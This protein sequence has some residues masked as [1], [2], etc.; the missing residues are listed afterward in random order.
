MGKKIKSIEEWP[1]QRIVVCSMFK[2]NMSRREAHC[3]LQFSLNLTLVLALKKIFLH[4]FH[5]SEHYDHKVWFGR[6]GLE[7]IDWEQRQE[8]SWSELLNKKSILKQ[9]FFLEQLSGYWKLNLHNGSGEKWEKQRF[10]KKEKK[11]NCI[12]IFIIC[13]LFRIPRIKFYKQIEI[14]RETTSILL[15]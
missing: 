5:W 12:V 11:D 9:K 14:D 2:E 3:Y 6:R 7:K 13:N 15:A 8:C 1:A 10:L 4:T